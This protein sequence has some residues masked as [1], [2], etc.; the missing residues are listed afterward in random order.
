MIDLIKKYKNGLAY[1]I[2]V[3]AV[4]YSINQVNDLTK[5]QL[6]NR[7]KNVATWCNAIN[8][9]RVYDQLFETRTVLQAKNRGI[10]LENALNQQ[11][12]LSAAD[13]AFANLYIKVIVNTLDKSHGVLILHPY[14]LSALDCKAIENSTAKSSK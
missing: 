5:S 13:K 10:A 1:A 7:V 14:R 2:L 11:H 12:Q 6:N 4:I 9:N 3:V 8:Q